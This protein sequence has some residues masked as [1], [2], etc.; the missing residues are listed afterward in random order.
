VHAAG[1]KSPP[2]TDPAVVAASPELTNNDSGPAELRRI[3]S[4][5]H[6]EDVRELMVRNGDSTKKIVILELGWTVDPRPDS[7][8]RWHAVTPEQQ[9]KYLQRAYA[10]AEANWQP[11][12]GVMSLIYIADPA[13]DMGMEET[14]WSVVYPGYPELRTS[15]AYYGHLYMPKV[16]PATAD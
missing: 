1:Y 16:P 10:Y 12:I 14:Y 7:P 9:D 5:R 3:Y 4:F 2:E 11:W 13:W 6:V 8:Y 15:P